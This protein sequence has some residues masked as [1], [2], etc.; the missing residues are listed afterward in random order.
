MRYLI[1]TDGHP[2]FLSKWF[3]P[4]DH[5]NASLNMVVFDL[6]IGIYTKDGKTWTDI[7]IDHL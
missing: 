3:Y 7:L 5:F 4:E 6:A 1:L 2:P